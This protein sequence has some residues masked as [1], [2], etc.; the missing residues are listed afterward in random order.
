L[1][2]H[3][4]CWGATLRAGFVTPCFLA[5]VIDGAEPA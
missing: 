1:K 5:F 3:A 4:H 2:I